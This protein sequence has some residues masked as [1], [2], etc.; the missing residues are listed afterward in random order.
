[1]VTLEVDRANVRSKVVVSVVVAFGVVAGAVAIGSVVRVRYYHDCCP[2]SLAFHSGAS[3]AAAMTML[4]TEVREGCRK[5]RLKSRT[6]SV[7]GLGRGYCYRWWSTLS[8]PA[9]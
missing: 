3:P 6:T 9:R 4:Q 2:G 5:P 1:M 8:S 7:L